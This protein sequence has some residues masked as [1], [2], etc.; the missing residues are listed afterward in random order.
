MSSTDTDKQKALRVFFREQLV[1]L[2]ASCAGGARLPLKGD[3][4]I[5]SYY[6]RRDAEAQY[7]F[8]LD[9]ANAEAHLAE[10]WRDEPEL[11][12]V[13]RPLIA[14][15]E[16]LSERSEASAEISPFVYAMF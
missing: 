2:A 11:L 13:V 9:T 6:R 14:L 4:S 3:P 7:V 1:P 12:A 16:S 5:A 15:A 8:E 10:M